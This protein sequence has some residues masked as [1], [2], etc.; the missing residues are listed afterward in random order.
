MI[1]I[2]FFRYQLDDILIINTVRYNVIPIGIRITTPAIKL[3]R[4]EDNSDFLVYF[5]PFQN[6]FKYK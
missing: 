3:L 6:S 2:N 4:S 5:S 1:G